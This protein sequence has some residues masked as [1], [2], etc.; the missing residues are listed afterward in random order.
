MEY[1]RGDRFGPDFTM[2]RCHSFQRFLFR[3]SL[4]PVLRRS[5]I[6]HIFLESPDWNA[7][8]KSRTAR[9]SSLDPLGNN[10]GVMDNI[11]DVFINAFSKMSKAQRRFVEVKE[12]SDKLDEDL[13]HVEKIFSRVTRRES[14]IESDLRELA[15][16]F[17]KLITLEPGVEPSAHSFAASVVDTATGMRRLHEATDRDYITSLRDMQ[18]YSGALKNLLKARDQKQMD[19]ESL[20]DYL[21]RSQMDRDTLQ[22]G[23]GGSGHGAGVAGGAGSFFRNRLEDVRGVDHEQSRRERQRKLEM[24]VDKL[25]TEVEAARKVS[26]MFDEEVVREVADFERIKRV[27]FKRQMGGLA[28]AHVDFYDDVAGVWERYIR[29]MEA[30]PTEE[31]SPR[32]T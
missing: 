21:S 25:T 5:D 20:T 10:G 6:L 28:T 3:L 22:Q 16:Q 29:E 14:D 1:L 30:E 12:K 15:E 32:P 18:A 2:R 26:E 8:M 23:G 27:E 7:T 19:H 11:T 9:D 17:Q 24:Q 4:H 13:S 31:D